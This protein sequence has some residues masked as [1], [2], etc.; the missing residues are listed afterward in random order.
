MV[1]PSAGHC[2]S[3]A[4][5][6]ARHLAWT[7]AQVLKP[8]IHTNHVQAIANTYI[9][10]TTNSAISATAGAWWILLT[11]HTAYGLLSPEQAVINARNA[12][13]SNR[14]ITPR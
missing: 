8:A 13:R 4:N 1:N 6:A 14:N 5:W 2:H 3:S 11:P 7:A 12:V 9:L 10:Y